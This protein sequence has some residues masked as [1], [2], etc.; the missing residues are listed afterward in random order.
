MI[1]R[2]SDVVQVF[3]VKPSPTFLLRSRTTR[4]MPCAVTVGMAV[5]TKG[6]D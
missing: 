6:A 5:Q 4:A 3:F 1:G 2:S